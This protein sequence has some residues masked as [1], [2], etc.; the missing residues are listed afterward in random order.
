LTPILRRKNKKTFVGSKKRHI[1]AVRLI[2]NLKKAIMYAIVEIAGQQFKVQKDQKLYV[3]R[4]EGAVDSKVD[5][6]K[7]LLIDNDGKVNVGAPVISGAKVSAKI[8]QHLKDDKVIVF[9]KKRRKGY[10]KSNGHRQQLTQ[11][12]VESIK[13]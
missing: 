7:V 6:D 5:F 11:L 9:K 3:H 12:L 4:L 10:Q 13:A 2:F 8:I 1:F